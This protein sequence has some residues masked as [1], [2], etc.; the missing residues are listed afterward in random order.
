MR[1]LD[2]TVAM[3][4]VYKNLPLE[5]ELRRQIA[6]ERVSRWRGNRTEDWRPTAAD[7]D[8]LVESTTRWAFDEMGLPLF[9]P[10]E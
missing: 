10:A 3:V 4:M 7:I 1:W 6:G 5:R 2:L 9:P 8:Q